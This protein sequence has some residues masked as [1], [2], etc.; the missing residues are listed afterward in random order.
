MAV[1]KWVSLL[2]SG[3]CGVAVLVAAGMGE[4]LSLGEPPLGGVAAVGAP[5][6]NAHGE[7]RLASGG[8]VVA[9]GE[10]DVDGGTV[11]LAPQA[12][13]AVAE[14]PVQEGDV[15][16]AG[17]PILKLESKLAELQVT[18]ALAAE[19]EA[20]AQLARAK[21]AVGIH[22]HKVEELKQSV[23]VAKARLSAHN[24]QVDKLEKLRAT[25]S[26]PEENFLSAKDQLTELQA[27]LRVAEEQLGEVQ[28]VD[29]NL[30]VQQ[31]E[32]AVQDAAAKLASAREHLAKHTLLAP[33]DG[34]VLR[35]QAGLGQILGAM[36]PRP[37]V[38]FRPDKPTI[39]RCEVEQEFADLIEPG[40]IAEV[41]NETYDNRKW[42]GRVQRV[43]PWVAPRRT[44]WNKIH[45]L[46]EVPTVECIV[47]LDPDQPPARIGQRVR[48]VFSPGSRAQVASE[49]HSTRE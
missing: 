49:K 16:K 34:Q 47:D 33:S 45:E 25:N 12:S 41:S 14:I 6:N 27:A 21:Q 30:D 35:L 31:A 1:W 48:V 5:P 40:M 4:V 13:G 37:P 38:W 46:G 8:R 24:R 7:P 29:P 10:F 20:A 18:Q 43:A 42:T 32:A 44:V 23:V 22:A 11:P 28:R 9:A 17:Q 3:L 2:L 19:A 39:V 26:V 36:D 15:V